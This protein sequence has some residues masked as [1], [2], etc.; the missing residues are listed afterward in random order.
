MTTLSKPDLTWFREAKFGMFIHW[1]IYAVAAIGGATQSQ[2][3]W[4]DLSLLQTDD[5]SYTAQRD[6]A[7]CGSG[8]KAPGWASLSG[9]N[10]GVV[11]A[12]RDFWQEYPKGFRI[13]P[14]ALDVRVWP[15]NAPGIAWKMLI[16]HNGSLT[17]KIQEKL[18]TDTARALRRAVPAPR[19]AWIAEH[20][21]RFMENI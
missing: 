18:K 3:A 5:R 21:R 16:D 7:S 6:G 10:T 9:A 15:G 12:V 1:G 13:M 20:M 4:R 11:A 19:F 14:D 17:P 8:E 2:P